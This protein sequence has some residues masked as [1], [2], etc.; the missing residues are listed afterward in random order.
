MSSKDVP[1]CYSPGTP[2]ERQWTERAFEFL[3]EGKLKVTVR[4]LVGVS[5][6]RVEGL[7]PY[8]EDYLDVEKMLTVTT[9]GSA[10]GD[11]GVATKSGRTV[12][13]RWAPVDLT[14]GCD[15]QHPND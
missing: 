7:C 8:C 1:R 13:P 3:R 14:C 10:A 4:S 15:T 12:L 11:R 9:E 2:V 5:A 6:V